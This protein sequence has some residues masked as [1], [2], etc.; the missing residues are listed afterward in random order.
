MKLALAH[1][2]SLICGDEGEKWKVE[3][4]GWELFN[5]CVLMKQ[6]LFNYVVCCKFLA[7]DGALT[8]IKF[9]R[10]GK[11]FGGGVQMQ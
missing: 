10:V 5:G 1:R 8:I 4:N 7:V 11:P 3:W 6:K 9:Y 2:Y